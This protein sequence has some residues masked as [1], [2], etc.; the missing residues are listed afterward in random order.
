MKNNCIVLRTAQSVE[1]TDAFPQYTKYIGKCWRKTVDIFRK[2]VLGTNYKL[3]K[4]CKGGGLNLQRLCNSEFFRAI[5]S[6][7]P[8]RAISALMYIQTHP[9]VITKPYY[10]GVSFIEEITELP[11]G[12]YSILFTS[13]VIRHY[14]AD[15]LSVEYDGNLMNSFMSHSASASVL[16]QKGCLLANSV[17]GFFDISEEEL[18]LIFS[19]DYIEKGEFENLNKKRIRDIRKLPIQHTES[20]KRFDHLIKKVI[21][22]GIEEINKAYNEER[23]PF[24]METEVITSSVKTGKRGKPLQKYIL[25]VFIEDPRSDEDEGVQNID[26]EYA[27]AEE[28]VDCSVDES[29]RV[30]DF[31]IQTEIPFPLDDSCVEEKFKKIEI[32]IDRLL[33]NSR[34]GHKDAYVKCITDQIRRRYEQQPTLVD[35]TLA[36]I[37]YSEQK[38]NEEKKGDKA[39]PWHI[40]RFLQSNLERY[41]HLVYEGKQKKGQKE[42]LKW[43]GQSPVLFPKEIDSDFYINNEQTILSNSEDET[44]N[45]SINGAGSHAATVGAFKRKFDRRQAMAELK[46]NIV[47]GEV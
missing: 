28:I 29:Q 39:I 34:A 27:D 23:C 25:R 13:A 33:K 9:V 3:G 7:H 6:K 5:D 24:M 16:Y 1:I 35:A 19:V 2:E 18:R 10:Y 38:I 26:I 15:D 37:D 17:R 11:T 46:S 22:P 20:Y 32:E 43:D 30:S 40:S 45:K 21:N 44:I 14:L 42:A 8:E 41:L 47:S 31:G 12:D 4:R 36:W